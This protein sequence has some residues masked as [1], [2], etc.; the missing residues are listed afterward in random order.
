LRKNLLGG[1]TVLNPYVQLD[2]NSGPEV[3]IGKFR[4]NFIGISLKFDENFKETACISD[5]DCIQ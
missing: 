5:V 4:K 3:G 1:G 2:G